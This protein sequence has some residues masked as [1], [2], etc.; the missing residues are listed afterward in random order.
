MES[1]RRIALH[2]Y[3]NYSTIDIR[4]YIAKYIHK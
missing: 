3:D 2:A 4:I 1:R